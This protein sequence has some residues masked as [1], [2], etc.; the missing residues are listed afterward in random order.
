MSFFKHFLL[1]FSLLLLLTLVD[2][3]YLGQ[4]LTGIDDAN[5]FMQYA[6]N[7][8]HGHGFVFHPGGEKVEGF[9]SLL[10]V[11]ICS[12]FYLVSAQPELL[13]TAF[14]LLITSVTVTMVYRELWKDIELLES[15]I[16]R[17]YFLLA[18]S[19]FLIC[20]GPSFVVW[21]V[22][23]GMENGLWN[24]LFL[25]SVILILRY[26]RNGFLNQTEKAGLVTFGCLML[27]TR[28]EGLAWGM[29]F[30]V[31]L[32]VAA[33]RYRNNYLFPFFYLAAL[34]ATVILLT[35]FRIRYFGYPLPNTYYAKVSH[36]RIYN[37]KEGLRYLTGFL[38]NFNALITFF[39]SVLIAGTLMQI[40]KITLFRDNREAVHNKS[41]FGMRVIIVTLV[42]CIG[43]FLPLLTGGDHFGGYRFYQSLLL[44]FAWGFP[45]LLDI[46]RTVPQ[47]RTGR[48]IVNLATFIL[49]PLLL[50]GFGDLY[51][52]KNIPQTRMNFEFALAAEGRNTADGLNEIWGNDKPSVGVVAVGGFALNYQGET[53]DLMGLNNIIMGHSPGNRVGVKNHA[54]FNKD[55]FYQLDADLLLPKLVADESAARNRYAELRSTDNFDNKAMKN[56][57]NDSLFHQH[58][59]PVMIS[60]SGKHVFAFSNN[61]QLEKMK[62]ENL[63]VMELD[64]QWLLLDW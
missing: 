4:P 27:L 10:W 24:F 40:K 62:K 12:V 61:K 44:L 36:D 63:E 42:I 30:I 34:G 23:S 3:F 2:F 25:G 54:A 20:I 55:I 39:F 49:L 9:T 50:V 22:L 56:I 8:A 35:F 41:R 16:F 32:F 38:T 6:R 64:G 19:A 53:I 37:L 45:T 28:P 15:G 18:F 46:Y 17:R 14:L 48:K 52:L 51:N 47:E 26:Y 1:F 43:I 59:Q 29:V 31:L 7:L 5:I 33:R 57:F 58:Y 13:I 11:I 21:S 60:R